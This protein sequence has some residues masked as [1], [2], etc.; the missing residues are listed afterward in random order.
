MTLGLGFSFIFLVVNTLFVCLNEKKS[1]EKDRIIDL[2]EKDG[3]EL[4]Q[5]VSLDHSDDHIVI[6]RGRL[7]A[8]T[9]LKDKEMG[10]EFPDD[11]Y[12][13]RIC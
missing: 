5:E 8:Q 1:N 9:L 2:I 12:L 3:F 7:S 13:I 11:S 6:I 10:L 4:D